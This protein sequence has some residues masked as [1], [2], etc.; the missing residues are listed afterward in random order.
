MLFGIADIPIL[1]QSESRRDNLHAVQFGKSASVFDIFVVVGV[2][3][4]RGNELSRVVVPQ[5]GA[6]V[7]DHAVP[8]GVVHPKLIAGAVLND[9]QELSG[10]FLRNLTRLG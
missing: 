10:F 9:L 1:G 2:V 7:A 3:Q 4:V 5:M 6:Q 8:D